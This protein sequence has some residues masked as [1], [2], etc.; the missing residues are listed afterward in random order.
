MDLSEICESL[1]QQKESIGDSLPKKSTK[2][3][4]IHE[5]TIK[6]INRQDIDNLSH[7]VQVWTDM[8]TI[9]HVEQ[10]F[11]KSDFTN[12]QQFETFNNLIN[13][14]FFYVKININLSILELFGLLNKIPWE[15]LCSPGLYQ[16]SYA[17]I[18]QLLGEQKETIAI[19]LMVLGSFYKFWDLIN[20]FNHMSQTNEWTKLLLAGM[21]NLSILISP[22][23]LTNCQEMIETI[24][25]ETGQ[26][27]DLSKK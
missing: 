6:T 19:Q 14:G 22:N 2:M 1:M 16:I 26:K 17:S 3:K 15:N 10:Q 7:Y 18:A 25:L 24:D 20:P 21:G 9:D 23:F 12:R 13:I 8:V 4:K 11:K 27:F 5:V